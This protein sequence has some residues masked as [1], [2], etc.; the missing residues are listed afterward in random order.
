M[1]CLSRLS[2]LAK[3]KLI[4]QS[5]HSS[6]R[7][8][9]P[10]KNIQPW[11]PRL[12]HCSYAT[13]RNEKA[14]FGRNNNSTFDNI[15]KG[16]WFCGAVATIAFSWWYGNYGDKPLATLQAAEKIDKPGEKV[17]TSRRK[18]YNFI[19]DVVQ[20]VA[21]SLVYIE[22]KDLGVSD[23]FTGL[24]VTSSNG[25]GFIVEANGLI[26]TNAHVVINKPRASVQVIT[27]NISL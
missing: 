23:Y 8:I 12:Q 21:S 25:S 5:I 14:D 26:L 10:A 13:H 1:S 24:P 11:L 18:E 15:H 19:A 20:E 2:S 4:C 22:I 17:I 16:W 27:K 7:K 9:V 6:S 3:T